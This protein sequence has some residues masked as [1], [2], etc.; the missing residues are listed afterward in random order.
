M[1]LLL[2]WQQRNMLTSYPVSY[3]DAFS[4]SLY[5]IWHQP[6]GLPSLST[7]SR[8]A[9]LPSTLEIA[10]IPVGVIGQRA[11]S[12]AFL[13]MSLPGQMMHPPTSMVSSS[14]VIVTLLSSAKPRP[15]ARNSSN[16][17]ENSFSSVMLPPT[18][19]IHSL[20]HSEAIFGLILS[21]WLMLAL[22]TATWYFF[23]NSSAFFISDSFAGKHRGW[24][25][26]GQGLEVPLLVLWTYEHLVIEKRDLFYLA[27]DFLLFPE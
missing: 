19:V 14:P 18:S 11:S 2:D 8:L 10:I 16:F 6:T 7:P 13:R 21:S 25:E 5:F 23:M 17:E 24:K 3:Q 4:S 1:I 22:A 27:L 12:P 20:I 15:S 9:F 26:G